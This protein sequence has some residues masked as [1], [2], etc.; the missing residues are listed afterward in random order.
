M[1]NK[2]KYFKMV[3]FPPNAVMVDGPEIKK[4]REA[5]MNLCQ[6]YFDIA[7][8]AIGED[9]VREKRDNKIGRLCDAPRRLFTLTAKAP[10]ELCEATKSASFHSPPI[11]IIAL[12]GLVTIDCRGTIF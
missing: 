2:Q 6:V 9:A 8:E 3:G 4:E 5:Y 10:Q 12:C 1:K 11:L 7:A